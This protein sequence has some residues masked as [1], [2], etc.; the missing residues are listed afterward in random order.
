MRKDIEE[1]VVLMYRN[2]DSIKDIK[3]IV[4]ASQQTIYDILHRNNISLDRAGSGSIKIKNKD[5]PKVTKLYKDGWSAAKIGA[6]FNVD[7]DTIIRLLKI[8]GIAV[9]SRQYKMHEQ[10][11]SV[12]DTPAKAYIFG[13]IVADGCVQDSNLLIDIR[14]PDNDLLQYIRD[15]IFPNKDKPI[16]NYHDGKMSR[17]G[18]HSTIITKD[19]AKLGC[20]SN[21]TKNIDTLYIPDDHLFWHFLRGFFDGDG[22]FHTSI[23][24][25]RKKHKQYFQLCLHKDLAE[26]LSK[27]LDDKGFP[28]T[29]YK[30]P[31]TEYMRYL[32]ITKAK[33][34]VNLY[35]KLYSDDCYSLKR[36][37]EKWFK[38]KEE[39]LNDHKTI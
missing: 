27:K 24:K 7:P 34:I 11:F 21:K 36:K 31:T 39:I 5:Y 20:V 19:L 1:Q 10:Y 26:V 2:G 4:K 16:F 3:N 15:Q 22:C 17:L 28:N 6:I 37:K 14:E 32:Y 33:D 12:I 9:T 25:F 13:F 29:V 23:P 18:I 30:H 38:R 35:E 8:L